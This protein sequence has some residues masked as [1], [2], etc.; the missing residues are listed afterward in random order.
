MP[1]VAVFFFVVSAAWIVIQAAGFLLVGEPWGITWFTCHQ[2]LS[3]VMEHL[4]GIGR[5]SHAAIGLITA[6]YAAFV[7]GV[8]VGLT[9]GIRSLIGLKRSKP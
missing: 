7:A 1:R 6:I 9:C 4:V 8:I 3:G 5:N 2:P